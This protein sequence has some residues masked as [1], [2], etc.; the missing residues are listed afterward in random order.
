MFAREV[1]YVGPAGT[2]KGCLLGTAE[3]LV[4]LPVETSAVVGRR[5]VT[6]RWEVDGSPARE[7]LEGALSDPSMDVSA[8]QGLLR[9]IAARAEGGV[10]LELGRMRR[11][12]VRSSFLS[13]GIY[14][15]ERESGPGWK[16]FP[17]KKGDV[18]EFARFYEGH[19]ASVG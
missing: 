19:P 6:T 18:A 13:R 8:L 7:L 10:L 14:V 1:P 16:G 15:S 12:R 4:Q 9:D 2:G 5:A 17:L 3:L 11:L